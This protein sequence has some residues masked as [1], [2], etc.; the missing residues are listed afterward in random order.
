ML[1]ILGHRTSPT[2]KNPGPLMEVMGGCSTSNLTRGTPHMSKESP[3]KTVKKSKNGWSS[4]RWNHEGLM[5]HRLELLRW[6]T[7]SFWR[8]Q[9]IE[10]ALLSRTKSK[11][12]SLCNFFSSQ[13]QWRVWKSGESSKKSVVHAC[14]TVFKSHV[15][16]Y[17]SIPNFLKEYDQRLYL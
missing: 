3:S 17:S 8:P 5:R 12:T 6:L 13:G 10:E 15:T 9:I 1:L 2:S 14:V 11:K 4:T 7:F 16:D